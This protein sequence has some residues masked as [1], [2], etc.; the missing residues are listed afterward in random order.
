MN[1]DHIARLESEI[2]YLKGLLVNQLNEF[3]PLLDQRVMLVR[4]GG[5]GSADCAATEGEKEFQEFHRVQVFRE[6]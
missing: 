6:W 2:R 1:D 4:S 3:L 5:V